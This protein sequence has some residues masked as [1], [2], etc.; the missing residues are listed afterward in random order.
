M[1]ILV[2]FELIVGWAVAVMGRPLLGILE[3]SGNMT[4]HFHGRFNNILIALCYW[5]ESVVKFAVHSP[6]HSRNP[7]G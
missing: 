7:A 3:G 6:T 4:I 2:Y 1:K 5:I